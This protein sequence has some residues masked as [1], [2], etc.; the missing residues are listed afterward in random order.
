MK[1]LLK[2]IA[3]LLII[4]AFLCAP[5]AHA[6]QT[7]YIAQTA[8]GAGTGASCANAY[9]YTFFNTVGNWA[10]TFTS[11]KISPNTTVHVCG[12]I[13]QTSD[14][15]TITSVSITSGGVATITAA[16][17]FTT[18]TTVDFY[19]LT[20]AACLNNTG[21]PY[22]TEPPIDSGKFSLPVTS[23]NST[24]FTVAAPGGCAKP[25]GPAADSGT[26]GV[27]SATA[28][29]TFQGSGTF[30][31][32]ITL[33]FDAATI[34]TLTAAFWGTNGA[35][36]I[37]GKS[38]IV[39]DG[40]NLAGTI[41]ATANGT[42]GI[43]ANQVSNGAGIESQ[44]G[45][46]ITIK[47]LNI[48]GLYYH[49]CV[50]VITSC[51]DEYGSNTEGIDF[52]P[53]TTVGTPNLVVTGNYIQDVRWGTFMEFDAGTANSGWVW[54]NN[55]VK[56][57][58]H[59]VFM[60][61]SSGSTLPSVVISGNTCQMT[62]NWDEQNDSFHHD[63]VHLSANGV[64]TSITAPQIYN[65]Y[66]YGIP[67]HVNAFI[68][69]AGETNLGS[70]GALGI[71]GAYVFNN[72]LVASGSG[73][74]PS[75]PANG[76]IQS[77]AYGSN[78]FNNTIVGWSTA[79]A[80][81]GTGIQIGDGGCV[82]AENLYNNITSTV[83]T[84]IGYSGTTSCQTNSTALDYWDYYNSS[85]IG[86]NTSKT[87]WTGNPATWLAG[88][89]GGLPTPHDN[90]SC[91]LTQYLGLSSTCNPQLNV[92][93]VPPYQL[94]NSTSLAWQKGKNLTSLVC[95]A[96]PVACL[97]ANGTARPT[98]GP[99]DIG[100]FETSATGF[101]ILSPTSNNYGSINVGSSSSS[102]TFSLTNNS[103]ATA[104]SVSPTVTG[105][106]TGDFPVTNSGSGSCNALSGTLTVGSSCT[107]T[108]KFSPSVAGSRS[109]T[110]SVSYGGGD[111]AS[112]QTAPL[113]GVG[114][115][116]T[117]PAPPMSLIVVLN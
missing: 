31:S 106:N 12:T 61:A 69:M 66:F 108:V 58:D 42:P 114:V 26:A 19:G 38:N 46:N 99:W 36:N 17:D 84:G 105:G 37:N 7:I 67:G 35:I 87:P 95:G 28:P 49:S 83:N 70:T 104:T 4:I 24:S 81:G 18:A 32:P 76:F 62:A 2:F 113:S 60:G 72:V 107:F 79:I 23:A 55:S 100:A 33:T 9:P 78:I 68:Y 63:C 51:V 85:S 101:M 64:S 41:Q 97:D 93:S 91:L 117:Y 88:S 10:G 48:I 73:P 65:N 82:G 27:T 56:N 47:N 111:S 1:Y 86:Y 98:T 54:S 29:F 52:N 5:P 3:L 45:S 94:T 16:N 8:Q 96:V 89:G 20:G 6:Q 15:A 77:L 110:L 14:T 21:V 22:G 39:I 71:T 102:V 34:G 13:T 92:S 30:G 11:G 40:N 109:T 80:T 44:N 115:V 103:V 43:Y 116:N 50:T 59:G 74:N 53:N 25:Y 75:G 57:V 112:P 90:N